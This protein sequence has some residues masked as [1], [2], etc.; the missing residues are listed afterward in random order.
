MAPNKGHLELLRAIALL[1]ATTCPDVRL[2][3]VG[4]ME[5]VPAYA[6]AVRGLMSALGL[7]ESVTVDERIDDAG[8]AAAYAGADVLCCL[9]VHEGFGVPLIEAMNAGVP[10]VALAAA[11]VPETT[12]GAALLVPDTAP[13]T[14]ATALDRVRVDGDLRAALTSAGLRRAAE[15]DTGSAVDRFVAAVTPGVCP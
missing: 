11:A 12:A 5:A 4:S 9:S 2:H 14:V 6:A 8:L 1:R 3:L 15:L 13:T 7:D 10:V